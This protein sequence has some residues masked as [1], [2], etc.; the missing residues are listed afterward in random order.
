MQSLLLGMSGCH[1]PITGGDGQ[2]ILFLYLVWM[3]PLRKRQPQRARELREEGAGADYQNLVLT[4]RINSPILFT[5]PAETSCLPSLIYIYC[6]RIFHS[7][8]LCCRPLIFQWFY[9]LLLLLDFNKLRPF[10]ISLILNT[11]QC[12][13]VMDYRLQHFS[14]SLI[15]KQLCQN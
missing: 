7:Q 15:S 11:V 6:E 9:S 10:K 13:I 8:H 5:L 14:H 2:Y 3:H 12:W 1:R 4:L